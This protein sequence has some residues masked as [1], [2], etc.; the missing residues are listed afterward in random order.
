MWRVLG[1]V[2]FAALVLAIGPWALVLVL[3]LLVPAVRRAARPRHPWW[4]AL[5]LLV[6]VGI[7]AAIVVVVPDGRLPIPPGP[8]ALVTPSYTGDVATPRPVDLEVPQHPGLAGNGRSSMHNDGWA[9]DTYAG[10]G[11]LGRDPEVDTAWYGLEECATLA[12]DQ[13]ERL[14]ALVLSLIHI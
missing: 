2:A 5:V 13:R 14:V 7:A 3:L 11:P 4:T 1:W 12:F 6:A 10:A 8:G 9:S